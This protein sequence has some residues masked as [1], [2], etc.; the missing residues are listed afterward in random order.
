MEWSILPATDGRAVTVTLKFQEQVAPGSKVSYVAA[1]PPDYRQSFSGSGLPF[2]NAAQAFENTPNRG[3][4]QL[5][6][7]LTT[8]FK[9]M[10]PNSYMV[11]LGTVQVPPTVFVS[12]TN[13]SGAKQVVPIKLSEPIPFRMMTYP[14]Q[15]TRARVDATFYDNPN[16]PIGTQEEILRAS[17]YPAENKMPGNFWGQRPPL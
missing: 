15:F 14:N 3:E 12:F 10:M 13:A 6:G 1:C 4:I 5:D 16:V 8:S 9:L 2:A 7:S 11:H 17:A